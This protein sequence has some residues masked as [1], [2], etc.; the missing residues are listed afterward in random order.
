MQYLLSLS[1]HHHSSYLNQICVR[2]EANLVWELVQAMTD[3]LGWLGHSRLSW[4][5]PWRC[6]GD[7]S[8]SSWAGCSLGISTV[9]LLCFLISMVSW[10]AALS[11]SALGAIA[12]VACGTADV[13]CRDPQSKAAGFRKLCT[14]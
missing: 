6:R 8:S 14:G 1:T 3:M 11:S 5:L 13:A 7:D 4:Q 12:D 9:S 10:Q 2:V